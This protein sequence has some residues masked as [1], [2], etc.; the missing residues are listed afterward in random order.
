MET[1]GEHKRD[2]AL[3]IYWVIIGL[4]IG[5]AIG[6]STKEW[7][8]SLVSGLLMGIGMAVM[9]TKPGVDQ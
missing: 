3:M 1:H 4:G 7:G 8:I 6:A 5:I 2:K 9:A